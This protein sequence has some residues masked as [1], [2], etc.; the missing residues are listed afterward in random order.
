MKISDECRPQ[1]NARNA[2]GF[3]H[4]L[5]AQDFAQRGPLKIVLAG[6][7]LGATALVEGDHRAYLPG[8]VLAFSEDVPIRESR[9]P[10]DSQ[11]AACDCRNR[12]CSASATTTMALIERYAA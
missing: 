7:K 4:V 12:T 11:P 6:D 8:R 2:F 3:A 10:V 9:H 1:P 5:S